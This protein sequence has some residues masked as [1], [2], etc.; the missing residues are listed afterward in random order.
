MDEI[1]LRIHHIGV[2]VPDIEKYL[3]NSFW[4]LQSPVV[5]DPA[6]KA[7]LCLLGAGCE[8]DPAIELIQPV[9]EDSPVYQALVKGQKQ[10]HLCMEAGSRKRTDAFIKK[11]GLL[12]VTGWT[13]ATL[14]HEQH[15]CFVFT[16]NHEL[17]EFVADD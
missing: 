3:E 1:Q 2:V 7:R 6:Q 5:Y 13:K 4:T 14:F 10:H 11:H 17:L 16:K 9:G 12:R 8:S 15:V